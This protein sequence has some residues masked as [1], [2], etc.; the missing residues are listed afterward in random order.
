MSASTIFILY[1]QAPA[2]LTYSADFAFSPLWWSKLVFL[3]IISSVCQ[4]LQQSGVWRPSITAELP[5]WIHVLALRVYLFYSKTW[6]FFCNQME[7][8][9]ECWRQETCSLWLWT[10]DLP[11][12]VGVS[13]DGPS[14]LRRIR[15][16]MLN[17][18]HYFL[19]LFARRNKIN[20]DRNW[21]TMT[22]SVPRLLDSVN[23]LL[24]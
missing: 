18:F 15:V 13:W 16:S 8:V 4:P 2:Q 6:Y 5:H 23:R 20:L 19:R 22:H 11:L 17:S 21:P 24:Y 9:C 12:G 3:I 1:F 7:F 10:P 14:H